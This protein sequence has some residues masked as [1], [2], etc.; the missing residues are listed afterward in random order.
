VFSCCVSDVVFNEN[1]KFFLVDICEKGA[2]P[3]CRQGGWSS[4]L[5]ISAAVHNSCGKSLLSD[6]VP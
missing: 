4:Y 1:A 2:M 5:H 3:D 6:D